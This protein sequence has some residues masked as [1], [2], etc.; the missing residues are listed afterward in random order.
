MY[1]GTKED[2]AEESQQAAT[3][4]Q[5]E[6]EEKQQQ[7]R[8]YPWNWFSDATWLG[9]GI[10]ILFFIIIPTMSVIVLANIIGYALKWLLYDYNPVGKFIL[11]TL[12]KTQRAL[13]QQIGNVILLD[14]R[15]A[16]YLPWMVWGDFYSACGLLLGLSAVSALWIGDLDVPHLSFAASW[17][18]TSNV[19]ASRNV[20]AQGRPRVSSRVVS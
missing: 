16:S 3:E 20:G 14:P 5:Q 2:E 4:Q 17:T 12:R 8:P 7:Q 15:D 6:E 1:P 19:C 9:L 11:K 10:G 13:F 18:T